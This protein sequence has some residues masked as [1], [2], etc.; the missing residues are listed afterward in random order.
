MILV[1][2]PTTVHPQEY[3]FHTPFEL[4]RS[5]KLWSDPRRTNL[6][7]RWWDC[8]NIDDRFEWGKNQI[9]WKP[10][11][12]SEG[13]HSKGLVE[14]IYW[15]TFYRYETQISNW[16]FIGP[17]DYG[18]YAVSMRSGWPKVFL[19]LDSLF[20]FRRAH[21]YKQPTRAN[22]CEKFEFNLT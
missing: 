6:Q 16:I 9:P 20:I 19:V 4:F 13:C 7:H 22:S 12:G 8:C 11:I 18:V 21:H 1:W 15:S 2:H 17:T 3:S 5:L 14:P 10:K